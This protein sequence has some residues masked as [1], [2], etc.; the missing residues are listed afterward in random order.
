[1]TIP[2]LREIAVLDEA[3]QSRGVAATADVSEAIAGGTMSFAG[4]GSWANQAIGLGMSGPVCD[5][6]VERFI[7]FYESRGVEP[8]IEVCPL[9]DES[10]V[11][12]LAVRGF[13]VREFKNLLFRRLDDPGAEP[14]PAPP[15][16]IEVTRV[17][18]ADADAVE[19]LVAIKLAGFESAAP[20]VDARLARQTLV[21]RGVAGYVA[22]IGG[23]AVAAGSTDLLPPVAGLFGMTTLAPYRRRGCQQALLIAR[24][25][26]AA[27]AG[28]RYATIQSM[29]HVGTARNA[30]RL[31]FAVAYT[32][33]TL[34]RPREGLARSH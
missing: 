28:C 26:A 24:L 10:F 2:D 16:G 25:R 13:V 11:D 8:R 30:M 23:E 5:A 9:A 17:D 1:M 29:P 12:A 34:V 32:K 27:D 6:D 20:E 31:G 7:H 19:R 21:V 3:R 22:W 18:S 14:L 15:A 4:I 33:V